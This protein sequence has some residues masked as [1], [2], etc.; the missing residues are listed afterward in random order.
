ALPD[1]LEV[2]GEVFLRLEDFEK[3]NAELGEA[4][5][6]LFANPRNAA[7]GMLRQK[8]PSATAARPL[9][10]YFH[11]LVRIDGVPLASY[12]A[13]VDYLR[14]PGLRVQPDAKHCPTLAGAK[15][16][17]SS[18]L[19]R[20]HALDHEIDGAVLKVDDHAAQAELGA[21]SK[22]PRWAIAFKFPAEEQTTK[23]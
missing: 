11:G 7:A 21:T 12:R 19:E 18:L 5:K 20:R 9:S 1:W 2:R 8:D 16:V 23:L 4:K 3:I 14:E 17:V 6:A 22:A 13:T 10:I 15:K